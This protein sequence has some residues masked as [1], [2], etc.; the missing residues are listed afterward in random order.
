Q[1]ITADIDLERLL[2]DR[3]RSTSFNDSV[4]DC[5]DRVR[6]IRRVPFEFFLP[7]K[8]VPLQRNVSRFPYVPAAAA[9]RGQRCYEADNIPVTGLVK[10]LASTG[11]SKVVIGVSG[12]LDSTQALI[13]AAKTMDHLNLPR[14][15]VLA[16]T[17][18][19]FATS[20]LTLKNA[21]RLMQ[22]MGVSAE[23]IDI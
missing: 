20:D 14:K 17:M 13:V 9:A 10:R 23:L 6:A 16:Y 2:Q 1:M 7:A 21:Q 19:G 12:G 8:T 4:H 18:P 15:N 22:V 5:L 11:I 3:M